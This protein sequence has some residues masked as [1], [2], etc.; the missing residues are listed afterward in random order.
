MKRICY[1]ACL[2]LILLSSCKTITKVVE[3]PVIKTEYIVKEKTD[4]ILIHDSIDRV[5]KNDSI[6]I[7]RWHTKYKY[8]HC[9]DTVIKNDTITQTVTVTETVVEYRV[10][11]V[12]KFFIWIGVITLIL[13]ILYIVLFILKKI[14][15]K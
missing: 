9:V 12:Q 11:K 6:I 14:Y 1:I 2:L 5:I 8:I 13:I 4:S 15:L 3:V 7:D 10:S